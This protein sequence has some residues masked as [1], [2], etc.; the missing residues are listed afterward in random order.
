MKG[1][2][3]F[4]H[5]VQT[6]SAEAQTLEKNSTIVT[7]AIGPLT[8]NVRLREVPSML[9]KDRQACQGDHTEGL[10]AGDSRVQKVSVSQRGLVGS[11]GRR[12]HMD[13]I[14]IPLSSGWHCH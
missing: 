9:G 5:G 11:W 14:D 12:P 10:E 2:I 13:P 8:R 6:R 3:P 4:S 7:E 1:D